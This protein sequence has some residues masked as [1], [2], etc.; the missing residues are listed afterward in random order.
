ME[1]LLKI[2]E[3]SISRTDLLEEN[4]FLDTTASIGKLF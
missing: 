3:N 1:Q 4:A 2:L